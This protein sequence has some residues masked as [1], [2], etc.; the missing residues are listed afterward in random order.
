[1]LATLK[2]KALLFGVVVA[3]AAAAVVCGN[4]SLY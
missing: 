1:M 4:V 2:T 3:T